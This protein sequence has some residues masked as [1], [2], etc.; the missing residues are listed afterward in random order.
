MADDF[1]TALARFRA[2]ANPP[3]DRA[4]CLAAATEHDLCVEHVVSTALGRRS[5]IATALAD[6]AVLANKAAS[7]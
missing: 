7:A 1:A 2:G 6:A 5:E 3:D 4:R